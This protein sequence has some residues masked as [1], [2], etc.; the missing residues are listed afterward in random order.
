MRYFY[1]QPQTIQGKKALITEP[2]AGHIRKVLRLKPDDSIGLLDGEGFEYLARI[3]E[4]SNHGIHVLIENQFPCTTESPL[5]LTLA[6]GFLKE[7]KM[8]DLVRQLT[9]LGVNRWLPFMAERSISRPDE[10]QLTRRM[11]RWRTISSQAI[12]QC[13]RGRFMDIERALSFQDMVLS[14]KNHDLALL[15]W[16]EETRPLREIQASFGAHPIA[17]VFIVIGPEGGLTQEEVGHAKAA[18][19]HIAGL[20]P[21]IL[22]AE[23]ATLAACSLI[24]HLFGDLG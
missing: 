14:A 22:K 17:S 5:S 3:E 2:D 24:Q 4:I 11:E 15:F 12:K 21:R 20:G 18:G 13:H 19:F 23:T 16:E 8:D 9:E 6:Q 1:I 7:S 10:K